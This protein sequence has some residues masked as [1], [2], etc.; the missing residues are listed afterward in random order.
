MPSSLPTQAQTHT[1]EPP[2]WV[3][4][5][6]HKYCLWLGVDYRRVRV[7]IKPVITYAAKIVALTNG[8]YILR[9]NE[10]IL[11]DRKATEAAILHE[12]T[13]ARLGHEYHDAVFYDTILYFM[14]EK[15]YNESY[16]RAFR[17]II[18]ELKKRK[19]HFHRLINA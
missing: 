13:H 5:L 17:I 3:M 14:S 15:E 2:Q 9:L 16:N 12:L 6:V 4:D 10:H 8:N 18:D 7:E 11:K 1:M 19:Q